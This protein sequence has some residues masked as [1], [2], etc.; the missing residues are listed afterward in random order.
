M[1]ENLQHWWSWVF[2]I[3]VAVLTAAGVGLAVYMRITSYISRRRMWREIKKE[4]DK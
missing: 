2:T 3:G 4:T 1:S